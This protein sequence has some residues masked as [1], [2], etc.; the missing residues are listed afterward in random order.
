[1]I[2]VSAAHSGVGTWVGV[3]GAGVRGGEEEGQGGSMANDIVTT[4]VIV[5]ATTELRTP[6]ETLTNIIINLSTYKHTFLC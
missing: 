4:T 2:L 1:M 5:T 3:A 6:E